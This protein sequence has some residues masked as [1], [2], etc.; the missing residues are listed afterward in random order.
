M[1]GGI[2]PD[3]VRAALERSV[4]W[5]V[6]VSSGVEASPGIKDVRLMEQLFVRVAESRAVG[7]RADGRVA[8]CTEGRHAARA[9]DR[10]DAQGDDEDQLL[11]GPRT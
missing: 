7:R 2:G 9:Q 11:K 8:E 6:D 10:A 4:A 3:N 1:A 5:G